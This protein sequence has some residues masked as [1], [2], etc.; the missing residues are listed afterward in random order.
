MG[1]R[2]IA[3]SDLFTEMEEQETERIYDLHER[4]QHPEV[5]E[6]MVHGEGVAE[7]P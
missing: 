2:W 5:E 3:L 7:R 4:S 6:L 1:K